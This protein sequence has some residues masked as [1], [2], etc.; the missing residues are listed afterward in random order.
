MAITSKEAYELDEDGQ[1]YIAEAEKKIDRMLNDKPDGIV[2]STIT[3]CQK[4]GSS[5]WKHNEVA[6]E[7]LKSIYTK[8][9]W[10]VHFDKHHDIHILPKQKSE[11]IFRMIRGEKYEKERS[12]KLRKRLNTMQNVIDALPKLIILM[13]IILIIIWW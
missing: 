9:G 3:L 13:I 4:V 10:V 6:S 11:P 8:A 7:K 2:L 12:R 5:W 1:R